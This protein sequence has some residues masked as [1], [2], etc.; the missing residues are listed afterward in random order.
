VNRLSLTP[1][2]QRLVD[3]MHEIGFG[4]IENFTVVNGDP[5]WEPIPCVVKNILLGKST[6]TVSRPQRSDYALKQRLIDLFALFD[7]EQNLEVLRIDIQH[8]LP[9]RLLIS[10]G[11]GTQFPT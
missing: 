6:E 8:G 2:R 9:L 3:L 1:S 11:K 5:L 10:G 4:R 7:Q